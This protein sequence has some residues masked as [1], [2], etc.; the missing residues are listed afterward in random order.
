M[1]ATAVEHQKITFIS[2]YIHIFRNCIPSLAYVCVG[3]IHGQIYV[4][5]HTLCMKVLHNL[6]GHFERVPNSLFYVE[7]VKAL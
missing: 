2:P 5:M 6:H 4:H 1:Y 3:K 7:G